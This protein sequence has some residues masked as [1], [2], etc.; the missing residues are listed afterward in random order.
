MQLTTSPQHISS[1]TRWSR[2]KAAAAVALTLLFVFWLDRATDAA[3]VQHLYYIPI[4]GAG[5]WFELAGGT[6]AALLAIVMYHVANPHLLTFRYGE[7]DLV[8][9]ALFVAVGVI[10][11]RLTR[12]GNRLRHLAATDDLTGLHNLRSFEAHLADLVRAARD[13]RTPLALLVLDVDRLKSLNDRHGHLTGA[14]AVRAVGQLL[15]ARLPH[16]AVACRYGGDEFAVVIP[17]CTSHSARAIA[18]DLR[19]AMRK[20]VTVLAGQPFEAGWFA[21]EGSIGQAYILFGDRLQPLM[22]ELNEVLAA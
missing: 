20:T 10:T 15:A 9:M 5:I 22:T 3:P 12:D 18:D 16:E 6:L 17:R 8:Q 13:D 4:I 19:L 21:Q 14:E 7:S 11:A 2:A 1:W